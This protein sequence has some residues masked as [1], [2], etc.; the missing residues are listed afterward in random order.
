MRSTTLGIVSPDWENPAIFQINQRN[1]HVPLRSSVDAAAAASHF[2]DPAARKRTRLTSLNG[3]DWAFKLFDRPQ[4]V[5]EDFA[6]PEFDTAKWSRVRL[7]LVA[8]GHEKNYVLNGHGSFSNHFHQCDV[9]KSG[10]LLCRSRCP[11]T[12]RRRVMGS[13]SV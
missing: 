11:V 4:L 9:M 13:P 6:S 5:P 3:S 1:A 12:G 2:A 8:S 10:S 7:H